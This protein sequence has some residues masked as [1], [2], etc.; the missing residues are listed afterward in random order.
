MIITRCHQNNAIHGAKKD[1]LNWIGSCLRACAPWEVPD[2]P[3]HLLRCAR[4]LALCLLNTLGSIDTTEALYGQQSYD[5]AARMCSLL[6][7]F[8]DYI[9]TEKHFLVDVAQKIFLSRGWALV[10]EST[11]MTTWKHIS[12]HIWRNVALT[13]MQRWR[14]DLS[15]YCTLT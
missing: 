9:C 3:V 7:A 10:N 15:S 11:S 14:I 13:A 8:A 12:L 1:R 2:L 4:P 6:W 5:Q